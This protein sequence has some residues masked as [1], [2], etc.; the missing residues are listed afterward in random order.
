MSLLI[1]ASVWLAAGVS[2]PADNA[3]QIIVTG[4]PLE[5]APVQSAQQ[6]LVPVQIERRGAISLS[7]ALDLASAAN[8]TTNSRGETLVYLRNAGERQLAVLFDGAALNIPWDN[9]LSLDLVPTQALGGIVVTPGT[10]SLRYG[11]N[12]A[13]GAIELVPASVGDAGAR[14][15]VS[16][17]GGSG[18]LRSVSGLWLGGEGPVSFTAAAER[19]T[20]D[21]LTAP[22]GDGLQA[23]TDMER[24]SFLLRAARDGGAAGQISIGLL[25]LDSAFGIAPAR[26]ERP[27]QGSPRYWRYPESRQT[28][29]VARGARTLGRFDLEASAWHQQAGQTIASYA[30]GA[31]AVLEDTQAGRDRSTG[32]RLQSAADIAG[33]T[34]RL[35]LNALGAQHDETEI[36]FNAAG[37]A[38]APDRSRFSDLRTSYAAE[39]S[40]RAGQAGYIAGLG[41]D[42]LDPDETGGRPSTGRFEA[43]NALLGVSW[44]ASEPW[45]FRAAIS[46]KHRMPTLRELYGAAL[47]R[48]LPNPGLQ[49]ETVNVAE[50]SARY[51]GERLSFE[52]TPFYNRV[53][54]TLDQRNVTVNGQ[55]L[56][57]R[58]NLAGS[59]ILG[60]E[61]RGEAVLSDQLRLEGHVL[62]S[63]PRRLREP[64]GPAELYLSER[65]E[66]IGRLALTWETADGLA[67][68]AEIEH[69]GRA[70]SLT[71]EDVFEP[72]A[73]STALNLGLS[74]APEAA[75]W[76]A[77]L[78]ADNV[79]DTLI[80]PQFGL[81][82]PGR[83]IR[84]GLRFRFG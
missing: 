66:L 38:G 51:R 59:E 76:R 8:V 25:H 40:G 7:E 62:A 41:L 27:S 58:I 44:Q 68:T 54:D 3:D 42:R 37:Q 65:P 23:N 32:L 80:E 70:F 46:R 11:V 22:D 48:F 9:R 6:A 71:D 39:F 84:A 53:E 57:Q 56:R 13:G 60:V 24:T 16:A 26:F 61:L 83:E 34:L 31:Y 33:G 4:K 35:A 36:A 82:A 72:L 21:G 67:A 69:R 81:P 45:R 63:R 14:R 15:E 30:S 79:T 73:R 18:G 28:L 10:L 50:I 47:N 2:V 29:L 75:G 43:V 55:R 64:G 1:S 49:P 78:R 19:V 17:M 74:W 12:S 77:F 52:L 5:T 20:R